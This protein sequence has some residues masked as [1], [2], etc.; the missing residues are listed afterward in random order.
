MPVSENDLEV[1]ETYLDGGA[2]NAEE[3]VLLDRL[4]KEPALAAAMETVRAERQL[5]AAVWQSCEPGDERVE[6]LM[7]R[8]ERKIDHHWNWTKRLSQLRMVSGA[9]AC[10][11]VGVFVGR[12]GP[13]RS[14][15][16]PA[17]QPG[18]SAVADAVRPAHKP[19]SVGI[20]N[21]YGQLV[22]YE[23]TDT[24]RAMEEAPAVQDN[25]GPIPSN[26]IVPVADEF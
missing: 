21:E 10:I 18:T 5:R 3:K 22:G 11:L 25:R 4:I 16:A 9:A 8:V 15:T 6:R 13:G 1:L 12:V 20:Y 24:E 14:A 19:G 2:G 26:N 17:V 7:G 23:T